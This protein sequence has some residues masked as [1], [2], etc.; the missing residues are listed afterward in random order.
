MTEPDPPPYGI[1]DG[2]GWR[3]IGTPRMPVLVMDAEAMRQSISGGIE[4]GARYA[5]VLEWIDDRG[6]GHFQLLRLP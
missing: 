4:V 2:N 1:D 6:C 5:Y 3:P